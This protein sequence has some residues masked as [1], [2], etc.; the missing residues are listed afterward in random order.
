MS[1]KKKLINKKLNNI[2]EVMK[3]RGSSSDLSKAFVTFKTIKVP[4]MYHRTA[5]LKIMIVNRGGGRLSACLQATLPKTLMMDAAVMD[6][7]GLSV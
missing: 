6:T 2:R 7:Q 1:N 3:W 5:D 4:L